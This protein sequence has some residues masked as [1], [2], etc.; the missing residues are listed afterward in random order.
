MWIVI[1]II[2]VLILAT[3]IVVR[4]LI[5]ELA[6]YSELH[7][8]QNKTPIPPYRPRDD[9]AEAQVFGKQGE[10]LVFSR[11]SVIAKES[12]G[13]IYHNVAFKDDEGYSSEIDVVLICSGGFFIIEVKSNVGIVKG[14]VDDEKWYVE[15]QLWQQDKEPLNPVKQNQGHI[16][17]LRRLAGKGFPYLTSLVIFPYADIEAVRSP[18]V[19]DMESAEKLIQEKIAEGK[20]PKETVER[21]HEQFQSFLARYEIT[22]E[23]HNRNFVHKA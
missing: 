17:H 8:D 10:E 6:K 1:V 2:V 9:L 5:H 22:A 18:I 19:H 14:G 11:L 12:G 13:Y 20:Y 23:E 3:I 21:F 16:N 4:L 15:K 7:D